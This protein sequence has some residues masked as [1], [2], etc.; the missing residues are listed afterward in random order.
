[1]FLKEHSTALISI[2][3]S[4]GVIKCGVIKLMT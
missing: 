3:D 4:S 2:R 1:M